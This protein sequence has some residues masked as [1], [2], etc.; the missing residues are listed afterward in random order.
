[1]IDYQKDLPIR[2]KDLPVDA[3]GHPV[4]WFVLKV[5]GEWDFRIMDGPKIIRAIQERLCWVCG[6]EMG[7]A[8]GTFVIGPM[9][10]VNRTSA[11]P[12]S[13]YDCAIYSATHCPWL[14]T[15]RRKRREKG[16]PEDHIDPAGIFIERNP[17]VTLV[18]TS[19]RWKPWTV[20]NG[21]LFNIGDAISIRW[22][23]EG[24]Q[25]TREEVLGSITSGLPTVQAAAEAQGP[26]AIAEFE[27]RVELAMRLVEETVPA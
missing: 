7:T 14:I 17:G 10:A 6:Q 12:P 5:R 9:C 11:E 24:R 25:A 15:P 8:K 22:F 26:E 1:M 20:N 3:Q 23:R 18:W 13:H 19:R 16:L 27:R 4:P 21:I 2:M